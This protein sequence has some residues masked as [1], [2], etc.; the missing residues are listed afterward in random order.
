[1]F[2]CTNVKFIV[3]SWENLLDFDHGFDGVICMP[4]LAS[5]LDMNSDV[6]QLTKF[7]FLAQVLFVFLLILGILKLV[8]WCLSCLVGESVLV[9]NLIK[10]YL[11]AK[12]VNWWC[13]WCITLLFVCKA[14]YFNLSHKSINCFLQIWISHSC[15]CMTRWFHVFPLGLLYPPTHLPVSVLDTCTL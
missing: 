15:I 14:L 5:E 3:H 9:N 13:W 7:T 2:N 4:S 10:L 11:I 8:S 12:V 1:M 6:N